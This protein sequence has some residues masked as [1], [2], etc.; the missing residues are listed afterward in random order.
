MKYTLLFILLFTLMGCVHHNNN[1]NE[2]QSL[3]FKKLNVDSVISWTFC[4][5]RK[6]LI[7]RTSPEE[8][9]KIIDS[10]NFGDS[11]G[12]IERTKNEF[13]WGLFKSN[14]SK[15]K[16]KKT[17]GYCPEIFLTKYQLPKKKEIKKLDIEKY[18]RQYLNKDE[19]SYE[20]KYSDEYPES[21]ETI[22]FNNSNIGTV[23]C[24]FYNLGLLEDRLPY[25][26][27]CKNYNIRNNGLEQVEVKCDSDAMGSN[28]R[29]LNVNWYY[30][31][32]NV[33]LTIEKERENK[34]KMTLIN[35]SD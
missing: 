22:C 5:N 13:H 14:W 3:L 32:G 9:G 24:L 23:Y 10:V 34:I 25:P 20:V 18:L 31:V 30:G 8:K 7:I 4:L 17:I 28:I 12:I 21:T 2:A 27:F 11:I 6:G 35:Q 1:D 26:L 16:R 15:V 29:K 33:Y 19:Y